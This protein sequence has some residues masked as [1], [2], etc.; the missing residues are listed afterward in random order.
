M[1]HAARGL[2]QAALGL[3]VRHVEHRR[4]HVGARLRRLPVRRGRARRGRQL[5]QVLRA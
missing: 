5:H 2:R 4:H 1:L 3:E